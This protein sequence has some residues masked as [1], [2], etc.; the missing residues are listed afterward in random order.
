[1]EAI[2]E[3]EV[4]RWQQEGLGF[5]ID[6][7][8]LFNHLIWADNFVLVGSTE[9][10]LKSMIEGATVAI[11]TWGF[12][13]KASSLEYMWI[14]EYHHGRR[15]SQTHMGTRWESVCQPVYPEVHHEG[16][17]RPL[18][19]PELLKERANG[20]PRPATYHLQQEFD[21]TRVAAPD[22]L[23]FHRVKSAK[24]LGAEISSKGNT[25]HCIAANR[26]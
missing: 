9:A 4:E 16:M 8:T 24:L 5:K 6:G 3:P 1:M 11:S 18:P 22:E 19:H 20:Q 7:R 25:E 14:Q 12:R 21:A 17:P 10:E 26:S 2:L 15:S 13:W 23:L